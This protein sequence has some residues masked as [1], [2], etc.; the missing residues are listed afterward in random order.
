MLADRFWLAT[1][2]VAGQTQ[3]THC[4][5]HAVGTMTWWDKAEA[6]DCAATSVKCTQIDSGR[7]ALETCDSIAR[8]V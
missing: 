6:F 8:V 4:L 2:T 5:V 7:P 1:P 3:T